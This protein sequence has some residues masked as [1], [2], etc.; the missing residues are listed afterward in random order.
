MN[1]I[2]KDNSRVIALENV[3]HI[4]DNRKTLI[5]KNKEY[6]IYT[7]FKTEKMSSE[8]GLVIL[9]EDNEF[10]V[11]DSEYFISSKDNDVKKFK[12]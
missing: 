1:N 4:S 3:D 8:L 12:I 5:I 7:S 2:V 10:H 9:C 6:R 11:I